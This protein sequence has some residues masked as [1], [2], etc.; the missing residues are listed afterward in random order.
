VAVVIEQ[1]EGCSFPELKVTGALDRIGGEQLSQY[2]RELAGHGSR[3][4]CLDLQ[5]ITSAD[6]H[7][8][9]ALVQIRLTLADT[10]C[11]L[12]L[13]NIP[14]WLWRRIVDTGL[15]H[16]LGVPGDR[17]LLP[18]FRDQRRD[19]GPAVLPDYMREAERAF[20][21]LRGEKLTLERK[22]VHQH[23]LLNAALDA[24]A[25][26]AFACDDQGRL[27]IW[28]NALTEL[29]GKSAAQVLDLDSAIDAILP[30][31]EDNRSAFQSFIL[32]GPYT[33]QDFMITSVEGEERIISWTCLRLHD[34]QGEPLGMYAAGVERTDQVR[35]EA[36]LHNLEQLYASIAE[37]VS[38]GLA[39]VVEGQVAYANSALS[40]LAGLDSDSLRGRNFISLLAP[41][42]QDVARRLAGEL[43]R[44]AE[45]HQTLRYQST[46]QRADGEQLPVMVTLSQAYYHNHEAYLYTVRDVRAY[47]RL[48][49]YE[50]LL[51]VCG[52]CG[53]IRES[54]EEEGV[55]QWITPMEFLARS[56]DL[57]ISHSIC[58]HC[59]ARAIEE[60][61]RAHKVS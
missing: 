52:S 59:A 3:R 34:E 53:C 47:Q 38:D 28:N 45:H 50:R 5:G 15:A 11:Q 46:L 56:L 36:T 18:R 6:N 37:N 35:Y 42:S 14:A 32:A 41:G 23:A 26:Y 48:E 60:F 55:E 20:A 30:D 58:P 9:A 29:T 61:E 44:R 2:A 22:I 49:A 4:A 33:R 13:R 27:I 24:T 1:T 40:R 10:N 31:D 7:G 57:H 25:D 54:D 17:R 16:S 51:T 43:P 12:E 39:L 21:L 8:L 19:G